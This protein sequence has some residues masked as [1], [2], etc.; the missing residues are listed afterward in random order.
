MIRYTQ[1]IFLIAAIVS[2]V[3]N[4]EGLTLMVADDDWWLK[5]L[6]ALT[7][8]AVTLVLALFWSHAFASIPALT[9]GAQRWRGWAA[10]AGGVV[11]IIG[12]STYWNL[13]AFAK[14]EINRLSSGSIVVMAERRIADASATSAVFLPYRVPVMALRSDIAA[15]KNAEIS[16][17]GTSGFSS[18]GPISSTMGQVEDRLTSLIDGIDAAKASLAKR[19]E[20][21]SAC[22]ADLRGG[23]AARDGAK[24]GTALACINAAAADMAAQDVIGTIRR[25]LNGLTTGVVIPANVYSDRQR[26]I[27]TRFL[28][29][30]ATRARAMAGEIE[31]VPAVQFEPLTMARPN[32]MRGVLIHWRSILPAI[33]TAL[34]I[35]LLPL[36]LLVLTVLLADDRRRKG[37]PQRDWTSAELLE[38]VR[39][40]EAIR[41]GEGTA[42]APGYIDLPPEHWQGDD[43]GGERP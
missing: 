38:A 2:G 10:I 8:I 18:A 14:D 27:I 31:T 20:D 32:V 42:P 37:L 7:G 3:L 19:Q 4:Y 33:A 21:A 43:D 22:L 11:L 35:D 23:I 15:T 30:T 16:G 28:R 12:I 9:P 39:Q 24:A 41:T 36:V 5:A 29:D 25:G 17:G 13:V 34:S 6:C 40:I 1:T 26:G